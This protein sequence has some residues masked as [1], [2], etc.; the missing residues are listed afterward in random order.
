[1]VRSKETWHLGIGVLLVGA[2][3]TPLATA[4]GLT[5][6]VTDPQGQPLEHAA[7][8]LIGD[9]AGPAAEPAQAV[10]DQRNRQFQ[11]YV[12]T[13][14]SNTRVQFPNSDDIRHHVYS[15]SPAKRFELRL[16]H[17]ATA[18]PV[19]FDRAGTV[20]LG[21][22][23]HDAMLAFIYVVDSPWHGVSDAEGQVRLNAL[24]SGRHQLQIQHP[25][26]A[27]PVTQ[28]VVLEADAT[29]RHAV[30]LE[31]LGPDPRGERAGSDLQRL[32]DR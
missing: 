21:C 18:D 15:F 32:F 3:C 22:N 2:L 6:T 19:L 14:Q 30:A 27:Q 24:P 11:P 4:A 5:V 10:V 25:R 9:R 20:T 29:A 28:P 12:L 7:V 31:A 1:M 17:G 8:A 26:L 13:V 16:Y 23:I